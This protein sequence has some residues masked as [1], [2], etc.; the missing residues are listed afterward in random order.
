V[1]QKVRQDPGAAWAAADAV[2]DDRQALDAAGFPEDP[3]EPPSP[4]RLA[5]TPG[6]PRYRLYGAD[7]PYAFLDLAMPEAALGT[8]LAGEARPGLRG[9]IDLL[10]PFTEIRL[11]GGRDLTAL[12]RLDL[13]VPEMLRRE[14]SIRLR[15]R[16]GLGPVRFERR[17]AARAFDAGPLV[18]PVVLHDLSPRLEIAFALGGRPPAPAGAVATTFA[19]L[20]G[21]GVWQLI[22][23]AETPL[24]A[25]L[26]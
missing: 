3:A 1:A 7:Y 5:G 20:R 22:A 19:V 21:L 6:Q 17:F 18:L 13:A 23:D 26:A 10:S 25:A 16:D 2:G 8:I 9:G 4:A 11:P 14:L 24:P 12:L 15:L